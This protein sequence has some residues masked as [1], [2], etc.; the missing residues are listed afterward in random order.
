MRNSG[1]TQ[2]SKP[3]NGLVAA[4]DVGTTK[5]C[6]LIAKPGGDHG[7]RI[8]GIGHQISKG[9]RNGVIVDLDQAEASIRTTVEAAEQM[10]GENIH[11]VIVNLSGGRPKS[12]LVAYEVA[13]GGHEIGD[14]DIQRI[15][16]PA[17]L[18]Q[19]IPDERELLHRIPMG[20]G[21][22][23]NRGVADP[24]GMYGERMSVNMHVVSALRGP[25]RNLEAVIRRCHLDLEGVVVSPYAAALGCLSEEE[26]ALGVTCIDMGGGTT[27]VAVFFDGELVHTDVL[28][29]G[30]AHVTKDI[31]R[32]LV[33]PLNHAERLKTL[34]GNAMASA[35]DDR[36]L[37]QVPSVGEEETPEAHTVPRS[38]LVG[39]VKPR[40]EEIFELVR[41]RLKQGGFDQVAGRGLV[42]T[43]GASQLPGAR[44]M[45]DTVLNKQAR[46]GRPLAMDGMAEA[47]AGPTFAA[48]AGL[49]QYGLGHR[50]EETGAEM[51]Q[52]AEPQ[53][54]FG[55]IGQWLRENF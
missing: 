8:V 9:M 31:A 46:F 36:Q 48:C 41:D 32:G 37:I 12:R 33:T 50:A 6:C 23:G 16:D 22:D 44:E 13:I 21:V 1:K 5:V 52:S 20:Y 28:P 43:G 11:E 42:L 7:P 4:L 35:N 27:S 2:K 24:R 55:R 47:S 39:I 49:L 14:G 40:M 15:L 51:P 30:G 29:I 26:K 17:N 10:A 54:R 38:V 25:L 45:A 19:E 34:Y 3:R 18:A 53:G